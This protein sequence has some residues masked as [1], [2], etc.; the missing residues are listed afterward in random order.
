MFLWL[1]WWRIILKKDH[2]WPAL[3]TTSVIIECLI[4]KHRV[5]MF[6]SCI[7]LPLLHTSLTSNVLQK[8]WA[9]NFTNTKHT[10]IIWLIIFLFWISEIRVWNPTKQGAIT[11][12]FFIIVKPY[13]IFLIPQLLQYNPNQICVVVLICIDI[14]FKSSMCCYW[15]DL[16]SPAPFTMHAW[17]WRDVCHRQSH[18][19][20]RQR[21]CGW[22]CAVRGVCTVKHGAVTQAYTHQK[23]HQGRNIRTHGMDGNMNPSNPCLSKLSPPVD[24]R[25]NH[26]R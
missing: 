8:L 12:N 2:G 10:T 22:I 17:S 23:H 1:L 25:L 13:F 7:D 15:C 16:P 5:F 24:S 19:V 14:R 4:H 3:Y 9:Q 21:Q 18:K 20:T 6:P 26:T 11:F